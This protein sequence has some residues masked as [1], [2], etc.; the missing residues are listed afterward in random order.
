MA[1]PTAF[2]KVED[3]SA[4]HELADA[5]AQMD[6][7]NYALSATTSLLTASRCVPDELAGND[8]GRDMGQ[9]AAWME[10]ARLDSAYATFTLLDYWADGVTATEIGKRMNVGKKAVEMRINRIRRAGT[11]VEK[12]ALEQASET[13]AKVCG[14]VEHAWTPDMIN[15]LLECK[16]KGMGNKEIGMLMNK[17]AKAV[18]R[19]AYKLLRPFVRLYACVC[20]FYVLTRTRRDPR[21]GSPHSVGQVGYAQVARAG[22]AGAA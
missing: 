20:V 8:T 14:T 19:K 1:A 4:L 18:E 7:N 2:V 21:I 16:R 9:T 15:F 10:Y 12:R 22:S 3:I 6:Y 13:R 5:Y 17:T 11:E